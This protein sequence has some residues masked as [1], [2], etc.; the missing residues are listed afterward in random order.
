MRSPWFRGWDPSSTKGGRVGYRIAGEFFD[1]GW[2]RPE[3]VATDKYAEIDL[4]GETMAATTDAI[5]GLEDK[6]LVLEV[7]S[8]GVPTPTDVTARVLRAV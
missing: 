2:Q 5:Q 6:T 1:V 4:G 7:A 8:V 3:T